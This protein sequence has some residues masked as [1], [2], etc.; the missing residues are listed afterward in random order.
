MKG[1]QVKAMDLKSFRENKLKLAT[2]TEFAKLLDVDEQVII[3]A[4]MDS[5]KCGL[6]I[7]SFLPSWMTMVNWHSLGSLLS[8]KRN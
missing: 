2:T 5:N 7:P 6:C 4:E 3:Q 1:Q 8:A